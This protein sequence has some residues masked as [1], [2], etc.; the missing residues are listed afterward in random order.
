MDMGK[1]TYGTLVSAAFCGAT[2]YS[3]S[4]MEYKYYSCIAKSLCSYAST[5]ACRHQFTRLQS[6]TFFQSTI[7]HSKC[8]QTL[9][10]GTCNFL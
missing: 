7:R 4:W 2:L 8:I 6:S 10:I 5:Y 3:L 9:A 1:K